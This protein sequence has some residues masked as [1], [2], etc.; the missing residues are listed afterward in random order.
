MVFRLVIVRVGFKRVRLGPGVSQPEGHPSTPPF[1]PSHKSL[2]GKREGSLLCVF[3]VEG[4]A[5]G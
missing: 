2:R 1:G 4:E 5:I 3:V